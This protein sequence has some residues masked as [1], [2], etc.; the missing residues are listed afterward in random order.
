MTDKEFEQLEMNYD[1]TK[2]PFWDDEAYDES[3]WEHL[4][5]GIDDEEIEE[6]DE[7]E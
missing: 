7:E 6:L 2:D 4:E 1:T 3:E 5:D